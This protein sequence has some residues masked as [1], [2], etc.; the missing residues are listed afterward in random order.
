MLKSRGAP[1]EVAVPISLLTSL[2]DELEEEVGTLPTVRALHKAGYQAGLH[3]AAQLHQEAGGDAFHVDRDAFWIH[4]HGYFAKRGWGA[5]GHRAVH[6]AIGL[7][8]SADWAEATLGDPDPDG[9]CCFS[10]GFLSGL[11]SQ[12]AG[13][14]VAVLEVG[15]RTRGGSSCDF[16]FG[17]EGAI[18]EL[19]GQLLEGTDLEGALAA[20]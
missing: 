3:A 14:P 2:R 9:S 18:H 6:D 15:C 20:L 5:L 13:G 4:L 10:T 8:S 7:L 12:I 19:Y 17:S 1:R 16:A 11:L